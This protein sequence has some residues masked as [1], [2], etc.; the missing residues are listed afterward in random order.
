MLPVEETRAN[1][2]RNEGNE[3]RTGERRMNQAKSRERGPFEGG[4]VFIGND[5]RRGHDWMSRI[6]EVGASNRSG[7]HNPVTFWTT[8]GSRHEGMTPRF[9][10]EMLFIESKHMVPVGGELTISLATREGQ[11]AGQELAEGI[12]MWHCPLGDEF[13]NQGGFGVRLQR[14]W[15]KEAGSDLT[16]GPKEAA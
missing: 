7:E 9:T 11:S 14:R 13:E 12:V 8:D 6:H 16:G 5:V 15:P 1:G 3:R 4:T 2:G 10:G